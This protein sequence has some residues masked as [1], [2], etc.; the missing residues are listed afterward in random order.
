[1]SRSSFSFSFESVVT[2]ELDELDF[3]N[4]N[5]TADFEYFSMPLVY[6]IDQDFQNVNENDEEEIPLALKNLINREEER[7]A[8]PCID[9]IIAINVGNEKDP[10]LVQI[11]PPLSSEK[12][13]RLIAF[14]KDFKDVFAWSYE[15][16]PGI[17]LEIV[18]HRIPLDPELD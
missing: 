15:D 13:E 11:R 1:M 14:L 17:D 9:E 6:C 10:C 8:K 16:M 3:K 12:R 18:Q 5:A 2:D 7:R 4:K